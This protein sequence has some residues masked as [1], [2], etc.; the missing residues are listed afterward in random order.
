MM[1]TSCKKHTSGGNK[2]LYRGY[3]KSLVLRG[4]FANRPYNSTQDNWLS[5]LTKASCL[6]CYYSLIHY[7]KVVPSQLVIELQALSFVGTSYKLAPAGEKK[8]GKLMLSPSLVSSPILSSSIFNYTSKIECTPYPKRP[9]KSLSE[10]QRRSIS[11]G[12]TPLRK[13]M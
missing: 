13:S 6:S 3:L 2:T 7:L 4:R 10:N 1:G 5:P 8:R 11:R 12:I 9:E